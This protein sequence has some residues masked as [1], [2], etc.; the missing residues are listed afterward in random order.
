MK[1]KAEQIAFEK[2]CERL[3]DENQRLI[4]RLEE[5]KNDIRKLN[6][7]IERLEEQVGQ[8]GKDRMMYDEISKLEHELAKSFPNKTNS[9][10]FDKLITGSK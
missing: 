10:V 2:K 3:K 5:D 4:L 1:L 7:K 8:E 9:V 6:D